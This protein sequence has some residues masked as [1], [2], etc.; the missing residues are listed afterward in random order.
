MPI[1]IN[2]ILAKNEQETNILGDDILK[3]IEE[4]AGT[5]SGVY[6]DKNSKMQMQSYDLFDEITGEKVLRCVFTLKTL[7][8]ARELRDIDVVIP[9]EKLQ[10]LD[11]ISKDEGISEASQMWTIEKDDKRTQLEVVNRYV[12]GRE[13]DGKET[14]SLSAMP[15]GEI[16]FG[17]DF[18]NDEE[19]R[20]DYA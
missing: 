15:Y 5:L 10:E 14:V 7:E 8:A 20:A 16:L 9:N 19:P 3:L 13:I 1:R 12:L 6:E 18:R 11:F 2:E 4:D 17:K